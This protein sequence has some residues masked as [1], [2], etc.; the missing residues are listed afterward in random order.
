MTSSTIKKSISVTDLLQEL[1]LDRILAERIRLVSASVTVPDPQQSPS[2]VLYLP[3]VNLRSQHN[4]AYALACHW[5]QYYDVPLLV[6][7]TVLDDAHHN[8]NLVPVDAEWP[9][10]VGTARRLCFQLQ[11]LQ[12]ACV[13]WENQYPNTHVAI[14]V[15]GPSC[16]RPHHLTLARQAMVTVTDEPFVHPYRNYVQSI[17]KAAKIC[18]CVDGSTTVPPL[19]KLRPSVDDNGSTFTGVPPKAWMWKKKMEPDMHRNVNGVV[20]QGVFDPP[21]LQASNSNIRFDLSWNQEQHPLYRWIPKEWKDST[22]PAPGERA[23]TTKEL[24]AI[25]PTTWSMS[26]PGIDNTV[27]PCRQTNGA[28]GWERWKTFQRSHL[29]Q[30][31]SRRNN[32]KMP[33]A[34]SRL[35]CFLNIGAISIFQIVHDLWQDKQNTEK[36]E[37]EILKWREISYA[38]A[39]STPQY[40]EPSALPQWSR[41]YLEKQCD[42]QNNGHNHLAYSLND[43]CLSRTSDSTW[44][45]MQTYLRETGELHNNARMTWG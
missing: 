38:H 27:P 32:I 40:F 12:K 17:A 29:A 11:A 1:Q 20:N 16:R 45:N 19:A 31:A 23:W 44:N 4:P 33:H 13:D 42:S 21:S 15:H 35:S 39:F 26:W 10:V 30:Y 28:E 3:T 34:V 24:S 43:L 5:A 8:H 14:R 7:C 6:L 22:V 2:F 18:F 41:E 36:F 25:D 9:I 37:D